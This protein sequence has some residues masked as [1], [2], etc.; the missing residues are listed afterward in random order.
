MSVAA[1]ATNNKGI[2]F[3]DVRARRPKRNDQDMHHAANK[4]QSND[5]LQW[6]SNPTCRNASTVFSIANVSYI[7]NVDIIVEHRLATYWQAAYLPSPG[8]DSAKDHI[9]YHRRHSWNLLDGEWY[10]C[11]S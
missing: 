11:E 3:I 8:K 7:A 10:C 4:C 6:R 2:G 1:V 9:A 5:T